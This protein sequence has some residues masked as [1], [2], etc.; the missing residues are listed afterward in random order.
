MPYLIK[1]ENVELHR[2]E[3][4]DLYDG[5]IEKEKLYII[6]RIYKIRKDRRFHKEEFTKINNIIANIKII[7]ANLNAI[8]IPISTC[9][10][11]QYLTD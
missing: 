7:K 6:D 10:N 1:K 3:H 11:I 8:N 5:D 2:I 9:K 4:I